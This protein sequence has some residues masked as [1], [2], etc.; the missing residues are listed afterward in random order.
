MAFRFRK[1]K[2]L[3][4]IS[5]ALFCFL[6]VYAQPEGMKDSIAVAKKVVEAAKLYPNPARNKIEIEVS[7]FEPGFIQVQFNDSRG[8]K[9]KDEKRL[10]ISGN[11]IIAVMFSLQQGLYFIILQQNE[12]ILKKK[13]LVQ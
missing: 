5:S 11:E 6:K 9:V 1:M 7:G 4:V 10:L 8:N 3:L 2:E 13:L 12:K